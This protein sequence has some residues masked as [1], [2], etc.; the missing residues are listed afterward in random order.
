MYRCST[1]AFLSHGKRRGLSLCN[2]PTDRGLPSP[3]PSPSYWPRAACARGALSPLAPEP[4]REAL[5]GLPQ[6]R[7][8]GGG[9]GGAWRGGRG[10]GAGMAEGGGWAMAEGLRSMGSRGGA[11]HVPHVTRPPPPTPANTWLFDCTALRPVREL[12]PGCCSGPLLLLCNNSCGNG[13]SSGSLVL[14]WIALGKY[15]V[16]VVANR[17]CLTT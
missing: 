10:G 9:G 2:Q 8:G 7:G 12:H 15:I 6:P 14:C 13:T 16:W 17:I 5:S 3:A 4:P 1:D 11:T